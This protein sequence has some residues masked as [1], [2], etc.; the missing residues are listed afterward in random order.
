MRDLRR[1]AA[2]HAHYCTEFSA[3]SDPGNMVSPF[4]I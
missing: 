4:A 1:K 2:L 3:E